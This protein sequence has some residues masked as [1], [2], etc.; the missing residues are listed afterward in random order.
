V[1]LAAFHLGTQAPLA[2]GQKLKPPEVA[3]AFLK[4]LRL[5]TKTAVLGQVEHLLLPITL[6]ELG[7][8]DKDQMV[9]TA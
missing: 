1:G 5:Q 7:F 4:E 8:L 6:E 9:A 2:A 3:A